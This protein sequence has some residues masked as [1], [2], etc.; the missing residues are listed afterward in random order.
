MEGTI[1]KL[2]QTEIYRG[3]R[4]HLVTETIQFPNGKRAEW[5]L[6]QHPGAA[7]VIPVDADGK[8]IMVRQY[9]NATDGWTL[10]IPAGCLDHPGEDPL[11]CACRELEEETGHQA[12][13]MDFLYKFYS[14]IGICDE[15]IHIYVARDLVKTEQSLDEDE[16]VTVEHHSLD[17][18][19]EMCFQ[20]VIMD[21]KTISAL[22]AYR[23]KYKL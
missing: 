23:Y 19:L 17:A 3:S 4:V 22:L 20:G 14:S 8:I 9:R 11:E 16:F 13:K 1:K 2:G 10:E 6:I 18:L 21:N 7:A 15:I 12:K 5:E